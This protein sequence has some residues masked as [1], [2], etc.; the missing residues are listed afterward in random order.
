MTTENSKLKIAFFDAKSYDRKMF[1][2]INKQF[3]FDIHYYK[4]LL[5]AKTQN[6]KNIQP[7]AL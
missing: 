2:E 5:S 3:G 4:V 6:G 1:D 7:E